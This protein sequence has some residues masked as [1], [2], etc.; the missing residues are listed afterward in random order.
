MGHNFEHV[1]A[2]RISAQLM[3]AGSL[4]A[5]VAMTAASIAGASVY[6]EA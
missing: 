3:A 4:F 1:L 6:K 5:L 2:G